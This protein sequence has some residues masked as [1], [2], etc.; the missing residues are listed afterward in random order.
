MDV[1]AHHSLGCH[2]RRLLGSAHDA[3]LPQVLVRLLNVSAT[4][5]QSLLAVHHASTALVTQLLDK[6]GTDCNL[7]LLLLLLLL[8]WSSLLDLSLWLGF[9]GLCLSSHLVGKVLLLLLNTLSQNVARKAP[10]LDVLTNSRNGLRDGI[11]DRLVVVHDPSLGQESTL[12]DDLVHPSLNNLLPDVLWFGGKILLLH[13]GLLLRLNKLGSGVLRCHVLHTW[14]SSN[15]HRKTLDELLEDVA[16]RDEIRLRVHLNKDPDP[17]SSMDVAA[18][19]SLGCH[20]RRLLGSAH[21]ALLPQ[22]LVRLLNVSAT[23][24]QSLLAVHHASTAL[25]TQL[26]D[27]LGT[28]CNLWLLL[29]LLLLHWSSLLDLSLWLG[30]L[31]LCLSR[32]LRLLRYLLLHRWGLLDYRLRGGRLFF[33]RDLFLVRDANHVSPVGGV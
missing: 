5:R 29:L 4:L 30:F 6:L 26:L 7:W 23:L 22:V 13:L 27:K 19:H 2:A 10:D 17:G 32:L 11:P 15:L 8:H 18:H 9:L 28:D 24:R 14:A 16:S 20:A 25:V 1:A 12:V 21:D 31:G 33:F 3:L